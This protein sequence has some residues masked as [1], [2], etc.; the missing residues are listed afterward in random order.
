MKPNWWHIEAAAE[1]AQTSTS[2]RKERREEQTPSIGINREES[3]LLSEDLEPGAG[4]GPGGE[5]KMFF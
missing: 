4:G 5:N 2:T 3:R 1:L